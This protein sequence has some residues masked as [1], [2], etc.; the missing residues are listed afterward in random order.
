MPQRVHPGQFKAAF[1]IAID[2]TN[3]VITSEQWPGRLQVFRY[4]TEAEVA[5]AQKEKGS[6]EPKPAETPTKQASA[7]GKGSNAQ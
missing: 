3:R 4:V 1:G 6:T 5:E 7:A 2:K